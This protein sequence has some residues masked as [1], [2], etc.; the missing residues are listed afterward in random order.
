M[1]AHLLKHLF[2]FLRIILNHMRN[3]SR[4]FLLHYLFVEPTTVEYLLQFIMKDSA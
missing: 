2:L 1:K 3:V 4:S